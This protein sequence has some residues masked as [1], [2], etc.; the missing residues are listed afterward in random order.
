MEI[1]RLS[2]IWKMLS[3]IISLSLVAKRTDG[4]DT[5]R[6]YDSFANYEN[7]RSENILVL[8]YSSAL[9]AAEKVTLFF[10]TED[11]KKSV[12]CS[13][14]WGFS[15][16]G[17]LFR[18]EIANSQVAFVESVGDV[19]F[20]INGVAE[21]E[22][23]ELRKAGKSADHAYS[24]F[25]AQS[26][27]SKGLEGDLVA[28]PPFT[29]RAVQ[30]NKSWKLFR[31][32]YPEYSVLCDCIESIPSGPMSMMSQEEVLDRMRECLGITE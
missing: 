30:S 3:L 29:F 27:L 5:L 11:G 12:K 20:Y 6:L 16:S 32:R 17:A 7:G 14:Y 15:Y 24:D 22:R 2:R 25:G 19:C 28:T 8:K 31:E 9:N 21:L 18:C 23:I 26:Y 10:K 4:A 1:T 13:E